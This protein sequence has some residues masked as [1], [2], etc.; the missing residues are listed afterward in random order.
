MWDLQKI[1]SAFLAFLLRSS[2]LVYG[3]MD[4]DI[5]LVS[6]DTS[7]RLFLEGNWSCP[8]LRFNIPNTRSLLN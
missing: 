6:E 2:L 8:E 3:N 5:F 1:A 4:F 7:L